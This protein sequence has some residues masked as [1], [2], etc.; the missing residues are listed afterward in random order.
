MLKGVIIPMRHP[1]FN[2]L[3]ET[4]FVVSNFTSHGKDMQHFGVFSRQIQP[5]GVKFFLSFVVDLALSETEVAKETN[6]SNSYFP[7]IRMATF[8]YTRLYTIYS[9]RYRC[10]LI[11]FDNNYT[12]HFT[13]ILS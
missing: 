1:V 6:G 12:V 2:V 7:H 8:N 9:N 4:V 11:I 3:F 10:I 13:H 5:F